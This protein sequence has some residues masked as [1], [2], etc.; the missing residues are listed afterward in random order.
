VIILGKHIWVP[1]G[2]NQGRR[3]IVPFSADHMVLIRRGTLHA[4]KP[5]LGHKRRK[6]M[7]TLCGTRA[8]PVTI[9]VDDDNAIV[10]IWP[11]PTRFGLGTRC[12]TCRDLAARKNP[13]PMY[14]GVEIEK[15][16]S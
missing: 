2:T 10:P 1:I 7:D 8:Y 15:V 3:V 12:I 14:R 11:T 13:D 5:T 9:N 4:A 16:A 6:T